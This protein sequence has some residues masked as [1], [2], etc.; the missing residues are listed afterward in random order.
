VTPY[1]EVFWLA[2]TI[3]SVLLGL[4]YLFIAA[5]AVR[6]HRR[7]HQSLAVAVAAVALLVLAATFAIGMTCLALR[8]DFVR[9]LL[10][11][12]VLAVAFMGSIGL[13]AATARDESTG[14]PRS[15]PDM[16]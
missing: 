5:G 10:G 12:I 11:A 2:L 16:V 9:P 6:G 3:S 1:H 8:R 7:F 13:V 14:S 15:T 4:G